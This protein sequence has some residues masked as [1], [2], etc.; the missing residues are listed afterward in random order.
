MPDEAPFAIVMEQ[1]RRGDPDAAHEVF[2]RYARGLVRIAATKLPAFTHA[3]VDPEDVVQ[4]VFRTFFRR[5]ANGEFQPAHWDGLW[6]LL[7]VLTARKAGHQVEHL[8]AARR[9]ALRETTRRPAGSSASGT[10]WEPADPAPSPE[11][12]TLLAE[13]VGQVLAGLTDRERSIVTLR[14][15]GYSITEVAEL[16]ATSERSV[17]RILA[18]VRTWLEAEAVR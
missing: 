10:A 9:S 6:S 14:L 5:F 4:S 18:H 17:H 7:A 15:Q 3:K 2:D 12:A 11:E 8:V 1:L 16:A 13:T